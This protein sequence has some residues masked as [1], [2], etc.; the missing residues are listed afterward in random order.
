MRPKDPKT[1]EEMIDRNFS[2]YGSVAVVNLTREM[3]FG[4]R[5]G[6]GVF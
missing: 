2:F 4:K 1:I 6:N 3:D 5:F